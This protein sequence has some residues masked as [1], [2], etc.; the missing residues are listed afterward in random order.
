MGQEKTNRERV[1][2]HVAGRLFVAIQ[3]PDYVID[4]VERLRLAEAGS[5]GLD[6][7]APEKLHLTLAFLGET[8]P[9]R[10]REI[11]RRL[12]EVAVNPFYLALEGL[13]VFPRK[14]RPQVLWAGFAPVD[15]LL[16]QLHGKIE[17]IGLDLGF[18]P[19]RRRFHPHVTI[20][21]C[22]P[23]AAPAVASI[24]KKQAHFGT[25]PFQVNEVVLFASRLG[26]GGAVYS[27]IMK[28]T[29]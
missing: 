15:P 26:P 6:W 4:A 5:A 23:R 12:P 29:F 22:R 1:F 24:L 3:P 19:D 21:R 27:E 2:A 13:G 8:E 28:V 17:R 9:D 16:F 11:V 10:Q 7:V 20:A 14:G 18:E 25:A